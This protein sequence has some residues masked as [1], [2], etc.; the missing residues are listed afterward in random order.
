MLQ[1][2]FHFVILKNIGEFPN[3]EDLCAYFIFAAQMSI[4]LYIICQYVLNHIVV[5][6][7]IS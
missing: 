3:A 7:F 6:S 1:L 2:V 5:I 4:T